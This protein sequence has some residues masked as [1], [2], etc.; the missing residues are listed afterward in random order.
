MKDYSSIGLTDK[1]QPKSSLS[2]RRPQR[3]TSYDFDSRYEPQVKQINASKINVMDL[4]EMSGIGTAVGTFSASQSLSLATTLSYTDPHENQ[5]IF[6]MVY[7]A[8]YQGDG[9][10]AADQ[11][12]PARGTGVTLG[13]Y[14]VQGMYDIVGWNGTVSR[15]RGLITDTNGTSSQAVT[16]QTRWWHIDNRSN[17]GA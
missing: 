1:L 10:A 11:I 16:F 17:T 9:T 8:L 13:R 4:I 15:W 3:V 6:G 14:D 7:L 2:A 12:Y 5:R